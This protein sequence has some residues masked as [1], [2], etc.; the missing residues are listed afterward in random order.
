MAWSFAVLGAD[1]Q[2]AWAQAGW[3]Y[4]EG[5]VGTAGERETKECEGQPEG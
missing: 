1:F 5:V 2:V 3:V 4:P